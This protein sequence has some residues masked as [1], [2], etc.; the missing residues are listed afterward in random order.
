M[1]QA[2]DVWMSTCLVFVFSALVEYSLVNVLSRKAPSNA[3]SSKAQDTRIVDVK[4]ADE[5]NNVEHK[6]V[7]KN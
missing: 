6:Q 2:I 7:G 3:P 4:S 5:Q 1:F